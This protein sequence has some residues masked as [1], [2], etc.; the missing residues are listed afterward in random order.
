MLGL[1]YK[2]NTDVVE[3]SRGP[4]LAASSRRGVDVV[5]Y[6]PAANG[7]AARA[8]AG[9]GRL[10]DS[11]GDAVGSADAVVIATAWDEFRELRRPS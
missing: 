6:D 5:V 3:E 4:L 2:P 8:L 9:V 11:L 1:S 10:A 7:N